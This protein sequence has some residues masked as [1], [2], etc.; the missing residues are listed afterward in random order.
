MPPAVRFLALR[1]LFCLAVGL[2]TATAADLDRDGL[3]D[4]VEQRLLEQF[5]PRFLI[6][7]SDCAGRPVGIRSGEMDPVAM[8]GSPVIYGRAFPNG[9]DVELQYFHLWTSDCGR[10]SHP[11]DVEHV[12]VLVRGGKA[13]LW[14][15]AAHQDTVCDVGHGARAATLAAVDSGATVWVSHGKHGSFLSEAA[16]RRGCGGD[17]CRRSL[18][19]VD[20]GAVVNVGEA[21]AP[22]NGAVWTASAKWPFGKK[23]RSDFAPHVVAQIDRK[24][25]RFLDPARVPVQSVILGGN[26]ALNGMGRAQNES[27]SALGTAAGATGRSLRSAKRWVQR[28]LGGASAGSGSPLSGGPQ[29]ADSRTPSGRSQSTL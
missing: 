28:R 12:S 25:V 6:S 10:L 23:F 16:C 15:A 11:W 4:A 2:A 18:E 20:V 21:D 3:D 13:V 17:D 9:N 8:T 5:R 24:G 14:F 7:P 22:L 26:H 19:E 27:G 1:F 29:P